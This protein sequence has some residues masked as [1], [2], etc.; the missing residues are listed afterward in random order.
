MSKTMRTILAA[1]G[2]CMVLNMQAQIPQRT[3]DECCQNPQEWV[4][5]HKEEIG[6]M[7][8]ADWL[9]LS[10]PLARPVFAAFS[11]EQKYAFWCDKLSETKAMD[12]WSDAE[13]GHIQKIID[14]LQDHKDIFDDASDADKK[15]MEN[16]FVEWSK[17]GTEQF[18]WSRQLA[19]AII[20][21]GNKLKNTKGEVIPMKDAD[22]TTCG[23]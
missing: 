2:L 19:G 7:T 9:Q 17:E 16:F 12:G 11:P 5:T 20:A 22:C 15:E 14:W 23:F 18:G 3:G 10:A 21:K 4:K 6:K 13:R 8:R 1:C